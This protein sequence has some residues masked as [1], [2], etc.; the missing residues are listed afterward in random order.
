M[1]RANFSVQRDAEKPYI[2]WKWGGHLSKITISNAKQILVHLATKLAILFLL[3]SL[4]LQTSFS[5]CSVW[6]ESPA[7]ENL[8]KRPK[9][10]NMISYSMWSLCVKILVCIFIIC[11]WKRNKRKKKEKSTWDWNAQMSDW[12]GC[13]THS[14]VSQHSLPSLCK[15][16]CH[17]TV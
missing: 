16:L 14:S 13:F 3:A 8:L 12:N 10:A 2:V 7:V 4:K 5:W 6:Q 17:P 15:H 1:T 11:F 9:K